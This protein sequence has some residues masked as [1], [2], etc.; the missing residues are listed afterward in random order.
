MNTVVTILIYFYATYHGVSPELAIAIAKT[1]SNLKPSAVTKEAK[2]GK[3]YGLFQVRWKTAADLGFRGTQQQLLDLDINIALGTAYIRKCA[4]KFGNSVD[5]I[6]CCYN[7]GLYRDPKVCRSS[8]VQEYTSK[9]K[10]N[11]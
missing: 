4:A 2:G 3:S 10:G 5:S 8:Q 1:E 7:A 11:L 9:V 6:A